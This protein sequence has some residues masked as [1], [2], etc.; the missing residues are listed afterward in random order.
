MRLCTFVPLQPYNGHGAFLVGQLGQ[1]VHTWFLV[2][3]GFSDHQPFEFHN[4]CWETCYARDSSFYLFWNWSTLHPARHTTSACHWNLFATYEVGRYGCYYII[5]YINFDDE[6]E[7]RALRWYITSSRLYSHIVCCGTI[8][9]HHAMYTS[10]NWTLTWALS[11]PLCFHSN[12]VFLLLTYFLNNLPFFVRNQLYIILK[13]KT[14]FAQRWEGC[15]LCCANKNRWPS[16]WNEN[17]NVWASP[18]S[19]I[20]HLRDNFCPDNNIYRKGRG[21]TRRKKN[22]YESP[23]QSVLVPEMIM[24]LG[25]GGG[26]GNEMNFCPITRKYFFYEMT[27]RRRLLAL[28]QNL[29]Q[30]VPFANLKFSSL[31]IWLGT[32]IETS[33]L[34]PTGFLGELIGEPRAE[35][36]VVKWRMWSSWRVRWCRR[37]RESGLWIHLIWSLHY[38]YDGTWNCVLLLR[39]SQ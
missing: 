23:P 21:K 20:P 2:R 22:F 32:G 3:I 10:L 27:R 13:K 14:Y 28:I 31:Q 26:G 37:E 18:S 33:L 12:R 5:L 34:N 30:N 39:P 38:Y 7:N 8:I 4:F 1:L 36:K 15:W 6:T 11:D 9:S 24:L 16:E 29:E 19:S 17:K 35:N 25:G